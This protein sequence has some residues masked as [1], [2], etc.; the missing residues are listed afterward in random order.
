MLLISLTGS[1]SGTAVV[2]LTALNNIER[3]AIRNSIPL[4]QGSFAQPVEFFSLEQHPTSISPSNNRRITVGEVDGRKYVTMKKSGSSME[5]VFEVSYYGESTFNNEIFINRYSENTE[6]DL[7]KVTAESLDEQTKEAL[8]G[9]VFQITQLDQGSTAS[10][11]H[12]LMKTVGSEQVVSYRAT[13]SPTGDDGKATFTGLN[14]GYYEILETVSP[15]GFLLLGHPIY[16]H[17]DHGT[18]YY[19][20]KPDETASPNTP[21]TEWTA[22]TSGNSVRFEPGVE[23]VV[24]D[25]STPADES[26]AGSNARFT[27]GDE[28]GVELPHTGGVGTRVFTLAGMMLFSLAGAVFCGVQRRRRSCC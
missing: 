21:I 16:V 26:A 12:Y 14:T 20:E 15:S 28:P 25:P 3:E 23:A 27:V 7:L 17:V 4:P 18:V 19:L 5:G 6:I 10:H 2:S 22:V 11:V 9:A 13:T 24:D 1:H 8:S